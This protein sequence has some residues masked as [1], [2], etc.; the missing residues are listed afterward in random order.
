MQPYTEIRGLEGQERSLKALGDLRYCR[1]RFPECV[2]F[3]Q[4]A[5]HE[6]RCASL[7]ASEDEPIVVQP[8]LRDLKLGVRRTEMNA[9]HGDSDSLMSVAFQD[10]FELGEGQRSETTDE[11]KP[12]LPIENR[13]IFREAHSRTVPRHARR[14]GSLVRQRHHGRLAPKFRHIKVANRGR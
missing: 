14:A 5:F 7:S 9:V 12:A 1:H 11:Q 3:Q 8:V 4:Q 13:A 6:P 2:Q 10:A